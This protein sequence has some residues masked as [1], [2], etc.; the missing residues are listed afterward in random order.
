MTPEQ[1]KKADQA[2][3]MAAKID[4]IASA[5]VAELDRSLRLQGWRGEYRSIVLEAMAH[6]ALVAA[7]AARK[8]RSD[9]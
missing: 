9:G 6:K 3:K 1:Q 5:P 4:A 2:V 7:E 8:E